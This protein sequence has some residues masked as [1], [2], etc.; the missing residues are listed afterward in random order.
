M[1]ISEASSAFRRICQLFTFTPRRLGEATILCR[2][3][4][5]QADTAALGCTPNQPTRAECYSKKARFSC[6]LFSRSSES[7]TWVAGARWL[8]C[9]LWNAYPTC[10]CA[11]ND[12]LCAEERSEADAGRS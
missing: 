8:A 11:R 9:P 4:L 7:A 10:L 6:I 1:G 5:P 2:V 12:T 3:L